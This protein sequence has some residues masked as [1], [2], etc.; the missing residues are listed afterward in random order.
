MILIILSSFLKGYSISVK[1]CIE[2]PIYEALE[3]SV[4]YLILNIYITNSNTVLQ[5]IRLALYL[6]S[7][8]FHYNFN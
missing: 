5:R 4:N 6:N 7:Y 1:N 8:Q 3:Y 2:F